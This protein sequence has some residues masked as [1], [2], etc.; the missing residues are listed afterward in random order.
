M[1]T[2]T[3]LSALFLLATALAVVP[4]TQ[5]MQTPPPCYTMTTSCCGIDPSFAPCC[6]VVTC[7]PQPHCAP[8]GV[9][10]SDFLAYL[11]P[12]A[13][14][15]LNS[16]CSVTACQGVTNSCCT[17]DGAQSNCGA[18]DLIDAPCN[19]PVALTTNLAAMALPTPHV[20]YVLNDDCSVTVYETYDCPAGFW[21]TSANYDAGQVEVHADTC[22][23]QCACMPM[24]IAFL[25]VLA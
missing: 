22:T 2:T 23:I 5:A 14:V 4:S 16:D 19:P 3:V 7:P 24:E 1:K 12:H 9:H 11:G 6:S 10:T 20:R 8:K 25:Q 13:G 15:D 17:V 21:D 18:I